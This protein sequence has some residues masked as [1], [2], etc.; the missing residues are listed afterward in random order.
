M[1]RSKFKAFIN[2]VEP[3]SIAEE[4]GIKTGDNL[5]KVNGDPV[6]DILDY[7][8]LTENESLVLEIEKEN[9]DIW[10]IDIEKYPHESLGISFYEECFDGL[11]ICLNNCVFCFLKGLPKG[12]R[13]TLYLRDDDYRH[14]FLHGNYITLTNVSWDDLHRIVNIKLS[15]LYI[16]V[17]TT[18]PELR[19]NMLG[20]QSAGDIYEKL[21]YLAKAGI[22]MHTQIVLCPELNDGQELNKTIEDLSFLWPSVR[23]LAVV[24]VGL[25]KYNYLANKYLRHFSI[26]ESFLV[27]DNVH[28][29]QEKLHKKFN[30]KFVFA[31]D[32]FF[33]KAKMN[34]PDEM[35]YEDY[36][37]LENGVGLVRSFINEFN[38]FVTENKVVKIDH[39]KRFLIATGLSAFPILDKLLKRFADQSIV[40]VHPIENRFFG[41]SITVAGLIT[42]SDI[43]TGLSKINKENKILLISEVLLKK[44]ENI[45]LDNMNVSQLE[46]SMG[47][48]IHVIESTGSAL[49][50]AITGGELNVKT[51]NSHSR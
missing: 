50:Q 13:N 15:P 30:S 12:M 2:H 22:E 17:H 42:G 33:L 32:E 1:T 9:G 39:N 36:P 8:L 6:R 41:N 25:T 24:P 31:S 38:D 4:V 11:N 14:S 28:K 21:K 46:Q 26:E 35:Y 23:S 5:L 51:S 10:E 20:S 49:A 27:L 44:G 48:K 16:S 40:T 19:E 7:H 47:M 37:Q 18:N 45:F 43:I 3:N 34:I 29:W